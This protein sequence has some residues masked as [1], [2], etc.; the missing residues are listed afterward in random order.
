MYRFQL[1]HLLCHEYGRETNLK[2]VLQM[3][4]HLRLETLRDYIDM[5]IGGL[6]STKT[7]SNSS[8][9]SEDKPIFETSVPSKRKLSSNSSSSNWNR[10]NNKNKYI[11]NNKNDD[12][13]DTTTITTTTTRTTT[14]T[15]TTD[16]ISSKLSLD[17]LLLLFSA[18][19]QEKKILLL[20]NRIRY[21]SGMVSLTKMKTM[22]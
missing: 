6:H 5:K 7:L 1:L 16:L 11:K 18:A 10:N 13:N 19:I 14:T 9:L 22:T 4:P 12:N 15:S 8:S 20:G 3:I 17:H 21:V 2:P